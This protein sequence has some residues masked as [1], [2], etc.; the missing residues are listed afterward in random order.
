MTL[1]T[2]QGVLLASH[3][4]RKRSATTGMSPNPV[5]NYKKTLEKI[6]HITYIFVKIFFFKNN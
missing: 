4:G 5:Y 6:Q 1:P 3:T 2:G